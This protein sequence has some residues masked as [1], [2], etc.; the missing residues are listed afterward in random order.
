MRVIRAA[1][2]FA[3]FVAA[4][5]SSSAHA[6]PVTSGEARF[7]VLTPRVIRMEYSSSKQFEDAPSLV[8]ATRGNAGDVPAKVSHEKGWLV[9]RTDL[10][11]LR[12]KEGSG[13]FGAD[14]LTVESK[15]LKPS[16]RTA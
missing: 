8:F 3:T 2:A 6:D 14:N 12:Y 4:V 10:L 16:K 5:A 9:I 11:T 7:T 15:Q 13:P 1:V